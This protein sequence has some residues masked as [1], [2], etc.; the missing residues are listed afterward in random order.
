M[1]G[2]FLFAMNRFNHSPLA[3]GNGPIR[4]KTCHHKS[5]LLFIVIA[6]ISYVKT[7]L[8]TNL[9]LILIVCYCP[10]IVPPTIRGVDSDLP[11][12]VTVLVNKTTQLE[13]YVVGNPAPKITWFKDSQPVSSDGPHRILSNGRTLQ[14]KTR[15]Q[16]ELFSTC[17]LAHF[18]YKL[19]LYNSSL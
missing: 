17:F 18:H 19:L 9:I 10:T 15:K 11:N 5:S 12:E 16:R 7:F 8:A 13:C 3:G 6:F 2:V 14:V 4:T 1:G